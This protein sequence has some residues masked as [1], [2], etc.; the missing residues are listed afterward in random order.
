[1]G[2]DPLTVRLTERG[3]YRP[4]PTFGAGIFQT[5]ALA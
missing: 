3:D 1:M 4:I 5:L 2:F